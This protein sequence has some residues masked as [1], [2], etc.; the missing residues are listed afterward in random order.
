M[1]HTIINAKKTAIV[2]YILA[3][4]FANSP[5]APRSFSIE[6]SEISTGGI[7]AQRDARSFEYEISFVRSSA[8]GLSTETRLV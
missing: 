1:Q 4:S 7:D 6:S 3:L 5:A 2:K 8:S